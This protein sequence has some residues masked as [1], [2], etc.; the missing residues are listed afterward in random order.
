[1]RRSGLPLTVKVF[2]I[3]VV[4]LF[5]QVTFG[6]DLRVNGTA[7]DFMLLLAVSA[8]FAAGPDEGATVGFAA[9]LASDLFLQNTP[10]GLSAL[11]YCLAGFVIGWARAN[12]MRAR[13]VFAPVAA[14]IGTA[15]GAT[16][17]VFIGYVVGQSQLVAPGKRWVVELVCVEALFAVVFSLPAAVLMA[18]GLRRPNMTSVTL[19][20]TSG[21]GVFETANRR[22]PPPRARRRRR[23]AARVR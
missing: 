2:F 15:V 16:L 20:S 10:F 5:V 1:M 13:L 23:S 17:F 8:G 18:W 21:A 19:A 14:G 7:P 4:V 9:G 6:S 11:A 12:F 3:L 22:R